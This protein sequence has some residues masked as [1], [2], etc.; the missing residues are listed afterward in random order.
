M[1]LEA[2][3]TCLKTAVET[4]E[5]QKLEPYQLA[6]VVGSAIGGAP[7]PK[8][9]PLLSC[10]DATPEVQ[11]LYGHML[12]TPGAGSRVFDHSTIAFWLL[13]GATTKGIAGAIHDLE[14]FLEAPTFLSRQIFAIEGLKLSRSCVLDDGTSLLPWDQLP[15]SPGKGRARLLA[16][17]QFRSPSAAL[18]REIVVRK[19]LIKPEEMGRVPAFKLPEDF[20][21]I[22][23]C[24]SLMGPSG[25]AIA[26][27]WW[28]VPDWIPPEGSSISYSIERAKPQSNDWPDEAYTLFPGFYKRFLSL[29]ED[30]KARLRVPLQR[31]NSAMRRWDKVDAAIDSGIALQ[32]L[33]ITS[34]GHKLLL[35]AARFLETTLERRKQVQALVLSLSQAR[36]RRCPRPFSG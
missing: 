23:S 32:S 19:Q 34:A 7:L 10:I 3:T 12:H 13:R 4:I 14:L 36:A 28:E 15:E 22:V 9:L 29:D 18:V 20:Q 16:M 2:L 17:D 27:V 25:A 8:V 6:I 11:E 24:A 1:P 31:L 21:D 26:S 5:P 33:F 35:R 30:R